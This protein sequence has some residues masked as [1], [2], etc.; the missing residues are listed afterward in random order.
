RVKVKVVKNKIAP[1][2]KEAE[3]DIMYGQGISKEGDIL[4]LAAKENIIEKSGAWYAYGGAKIGQGREN[5]KTYLRDNPAIC[6]EIDDKVR[7]FYGLPSAAVIEK[8]QFDTKGTADPKTPKAA[9]ASSM[10]G[11]SKSKAGQAA[12]ADSEAEADFD[13]GTEEKTAMTSPEAAE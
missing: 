5:A 12:A 4:D 7:A 6:Q 9:K 8:A 3:F 2:F 11:S 13:A 10:R 1:P